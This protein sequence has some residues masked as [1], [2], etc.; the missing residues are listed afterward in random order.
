MNLPVINI[1]AAKQGLRD[2][3]QLIAEG[4]NEQVIRDSFTSHLRQIFPEVPRWIVKHIQGSE[5]AVKI[6]REA[7]AR[8]GFV[9]NLVDLTA[10]EYESDLTKPA[11]FRQGLEQVKD[12]SAS[13]VNRGHDPELILGILSDTVKWYAYQIDISQLP[14]R[15]ASRTNLVLREVDAL[16]CSA[17]GDKEAH[18]LIRFLIKYLGR[19]GAR[20]FSADAIAKDLGFQSQFCQPH[21]ASLTG[22]VTLAFQQNPTYAKLIAELWCAFVSYLREEGRPD[23]F[24]QK[25][26]V[27]E[28]YILILGKLVCANF[29]EQ[30][31]LSSSDGELAEIINGHFFENKGLLNFV[32]Y[33][34]FG[35]LNTGS[36]IGSVLPIAREIQQDL[37][38]Y[39]FTA[40][41]AE[42]L[43]GKLMAQLAN[44]SQR[45]LL[46]QEWT[47]GWL[48]RK[49]V[50]HVVD[51]LPAS[52]PLRLI[53]MCCG[54]GSMIVEAVKIT[55]QRLLAGNPQISPEEQISLLIE[56]ITGFD[57]DPLAVMLSKINWVLVAKDL[58]QPYGTFQLTIP[59]Y[60]ADSLFA[61][62]PLS[63][64]VADEDQ[65]V[66]VLRIAEYTIHLP[67]YLISPKFNGFFDHLIEVSYHL[68]MA[69]P[70]ESAFF[71]E[72][73][74]VLTQIQ[75]IS[76]ELSLELL[77]TEIAEVSA[78][79][80]ELTTA[81]DLLNKEGRNGIWASIF[82]NSFRPGLVFGQFNGLVSNPPWLAL[83]RVA[84]NPYQ[85]ILK[86]MAEAYDIKPPGSSHL[87]IELA[88]IFLLHAVHHYL[89]DGAA[90]GCI[91]PETVLNGHHHN[92]FRK[93][94]FFQSAKQVYFS[95]DEIWKVAE[96]TFKN[97]AI[98]LY[99]KKR[100]P[101]LAATKPFPGKIVFEY[102]PD[103]LFTLYRNTQ[104]N[105]TAW[106]E[107]DL[108]EAGAGFYVPASFRQ[109]A[110]IMPRNLLF[111]EVLASTNPRLYQVQ[112]INPV[113]SPIAY[114]V[115]DA[116]KH[117][118]FAITSR[119]LPKDLFFDAI[120]SNLL[121]PFDIAAVQKALLPIKKN[122][123][124]TWEP[125]S[126]AAVIAKGAIAKNTFHDI[127]SMISP[128]H[129]SI[130]N[131]F[132]LI[133]TRGKLVQQV[134]V[135][136]GYLVMTG[137]G[138]GVVCAGYIDATRDDPSRLIID[139][140][141]Y[142]AQ[143]TTEEE[144]IYL[145]GLLNSDA[146]NE[147][148]KEFQPRGAFG[149]RHVHKLPFGVTPPYD[150]DQTAHRDVVT[151]TKALMQ[152]Y[153]ALKIT[154]P[155]LPALLN[156]N[157]GSLSSRRKKLMQFIKNLPPY[158][159][160]EEAC[161][162]LYGI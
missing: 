100:A 124:G 18:D 103:E 138:G 105:R 75:A 37:V 72:P 21:L 108:G 104:G 6:V 17:A 34:Y 23:R 143:V 7:G 81:I 152:A 71:L 86:K 73:A 135:P 55:K 107:Q 51:Q 36:H 62:T 91:V 38:A 128:L 31:S 95:I 131:L 4:K 42:D 88:T 50:G 1:D 84:D 111:Y 127:C 137:A 20:P 10:I 148:I 120:T 87:H 83:S 94:K 25:T 130:E 11:K 133:D 61:I 147:I 28:Y 125:L 3:V 76:T 109:G 45:L 110:D 44:R 155:A 22:T 30:R 58:I 56:T 40:A 52:E 160:Y 33:D 115:K 43:F 123:A 26:Y 134:I 89:I 129:P 82:R 140:T 98:V 2:G 70:A 151:K 150:S 63:N 112:S 66:Y 9:D 96:H 80:T 158:Q 41:P 90:I 92:P 49:L 48:S 64:N 53:D 5:S 93:F 144:A 149:E 132:A 69:A 136:S 106:S 113:S 24:D 142:W 67:V 146:I 13:L 60:H 153:A 47:P 32:E 122:S 19:Q 101:D 119:L 97:N 114:T 29:L 68:I 79:F 59:I 156:P 74:D 126:P 159:P 102:Q 39:D 99:G 162:A 161:R 145:T 85:L 121:T 78:F 117:Q 141:I 46:G 54:S 14:E 8:T 118:S 35:W 116:K 157:N 154:Q 65:K 27:D 57:I 15:P 16:D 12:Y 139:Q 77:E